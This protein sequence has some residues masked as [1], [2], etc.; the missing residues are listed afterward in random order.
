MSSPH[1]FFVAPV[2]P[3]A[4]LTS[5]CLG[6]V[7]ALDRKGLR[8]GFFKPVRQPGQD[9]G[10]ERSTHFVRK[11][12]DIDPIEPFSWAWSEGLLSAGKDDELLQAIVGRAQDEVLG[13]DHDVLVVE[14]LVATADHPELDT[15]NERVAAAFDAEVILVGAPPRGSL[16]ALSER[17]ETVAHHF[18]GPDDRRVL[19]AI[20]NKLDA[21]TQEVTTATRTDRV[22]PGTPRDAASL[23]EHMRVLREDSFHLIGAVPWRQ[24]WVSPARWTWPGSWTP[25]S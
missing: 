17:L 20:V 2:G 13:G 16:E 11:T 3:G 8:V 5:V 24:A 6:L 23:A 10:P 21:P 9:E 18:G 12:S 1:V 14:G 22:R 25:A 15:L 19:G 4:G 7:R